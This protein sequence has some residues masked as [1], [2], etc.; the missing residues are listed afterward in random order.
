MIKVETSIEINKPVEDVFAFTTNAENN[1]KWQDGVVES[2]VSNQTPEMVGTVITD[3][4]QLFGRKMESELQ[5]MSYEPNKKVVLKII[6]GPVEMEITQM[7]EAVDGGTKIS[8]R[9][10][11]EPGGFFK[12]VG[13][14]LEKQMVEQNEQ[15]FQ[16]LKQILEG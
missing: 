16:K 7:Y 5:V 13:G 10:E 9:M 14:A 6:K 8:V 3:V 1:A 2:R 15:N 11:G 12:L 4:R